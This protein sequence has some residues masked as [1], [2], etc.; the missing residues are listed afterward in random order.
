MEENKELINSIIEL[1]R[2]KDTISISLIQREL[3]MGYVQSANIVN[4]LIDEG[5]IKHSKKPFRYELVSAQQ[6]DIDLLKD[7]ENINIFIGDSHGCEVV[8]LNVLND[9]LLKQKECMVISEDFNLFNKLTGI[10]LDSETQSRL[11]NISVSPASSVCKMDFVSNLKVEN[12]YHYV[13]IKD[14]DIN[15]VNELSVLSELYAGKASQLNGFKL[16]IVPKNFDISNFNIISNHDLID[17][18]KNSLWKIERGENNKISLINQLKNI[19]YQ[20][21]VDNFKIV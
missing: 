17:K 20:F 21:K 6:N 1:F 4:F 12:T 9:A 11:I 19:D 16:V 7:L 8:F 2:G 15:S 14:V 5:I 13:F 18:V 3:S 10:N